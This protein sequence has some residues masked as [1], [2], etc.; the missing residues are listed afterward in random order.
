[1]RTRPRHDSFTARRRYVAM[2]AAAGPLRPATAEDQPVAFRPVAT[3]RERVALTALVGLNAITALVFIGWLVRPEH[4]PGFAGALPPIA[5]WAAR[6]G[7]ALVV[8]VE[9][10]RL[11]QN[12]AVWVFAMHAK[13]PVP[14]DPPIGWR[15]ALLTTIV[16]S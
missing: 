13:D 7:F 15:V 14:V 6:L 2:A 3:V 10:V 12:V 1:M 11:L 8:A 9:V 4:V 16:P 5:L